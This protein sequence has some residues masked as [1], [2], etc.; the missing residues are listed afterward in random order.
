[1]AAKVSPSGGLAEPPWFTPQHTAE[2]SSRNSPQVCAPQLLMAAKVASA[3][4]PPV[5]VARSV[6][7]LPVV[8]VDCSVDWLPSLVAV[9]CSVA[10]PS[11][12]V[13]VGCSV[14]W[15]LPLLHPATNAA[16]SR[17]SRIGDYALDADTATREPKR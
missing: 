9:G 12:P 4:P 10:C 14:G 5:G 13:G 16:V 3:R 1:M 11:P 7:W 15:P 17:T 2:P 6:G 8:G